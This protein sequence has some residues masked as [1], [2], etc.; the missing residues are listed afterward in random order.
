MTPRGVPRTDQ[1]RELHEQVRPM[2]HA[3][4]YGGWA[5]ADHIRRPAE[6]PLT[7]WPRVGQLIRAEADGCTLY[8]V[9]RDM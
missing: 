7:R 4:R 1:L 2:V 9:Q 3:S 6:L 5:I 8:R